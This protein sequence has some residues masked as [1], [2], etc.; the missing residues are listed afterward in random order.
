MKTEIFADAI[1]NR[2]RLQFFYECSEVTIEPY[3]I[4]LENSGRKV[5]YGRIS[6]SNI[7]KRFEYRYIANI[8]VLEHNRFA[9][10][11]PFLYFN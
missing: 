2:N 6:G 1:Q 9:P 8:K 5:I 3:Y 10:K 11:I 7:I 4:T